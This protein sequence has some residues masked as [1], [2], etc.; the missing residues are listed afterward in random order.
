MVPVVPPLLFHT[1][2]GICPHILQNMK[3][4][5][6]LSYIFMTRGFKLTPIRHLFCI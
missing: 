1:C 3:S 5:D 4:E 6:G 2:R